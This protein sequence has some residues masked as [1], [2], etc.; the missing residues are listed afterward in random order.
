MKFY[1]Y[2]KSGEGG[3]SIFLKAMLKVGGGGAQTVLG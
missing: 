3:G 1:P 2:K